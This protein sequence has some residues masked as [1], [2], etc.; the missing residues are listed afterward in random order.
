MGPINRVKNWVQ[1]QRNIIG[2]SGGLQEK[3]DAM[4][5]KMEVAMTILRELDP[6]MDRRIAPQPYPEERR[7]GLYE[8][9]RKLA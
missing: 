7:H 9:H 3:K 4:Q 2:K 5:R 1:T 6:K 8:Y